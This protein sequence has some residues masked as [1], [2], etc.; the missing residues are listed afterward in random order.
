MTV[1]QQEDA[2]YVLETIKIVRQDGFAKNVVSHPIPE[3]VILGITHSKP[4][5]TSYLG[6]YQFSLT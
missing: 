1:L 3:N 6:M 2:M 5:R 4:T